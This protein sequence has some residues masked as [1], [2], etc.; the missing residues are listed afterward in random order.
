MN[1]NRVRLRGCVIHRTI[2]RRACSTLNLVTDGRCS[3]L[4]WLLL[5]SSTF[6]SQSLKRVLAS[7]PNS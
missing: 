4:E 3:G 6:V 2:V 5:A 7:E 1:P